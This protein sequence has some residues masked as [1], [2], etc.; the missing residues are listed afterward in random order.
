M[1]VFGCAPPVNSPVGLRLEA[2]ARFPGGLHCSSRIG[3]SCRDVLAGRSSAPFGRMPCAWRYAIARPPEAWN[4]GG[5][6]PSA[7]HS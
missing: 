6:G 1:P 5:G 4:R 2:A 3:N 7:D